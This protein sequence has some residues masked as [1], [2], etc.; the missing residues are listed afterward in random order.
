M[1]KN[2]LII[3]NGVSRLNFHLPTLQKHFVTYGCNALY[4]DHMPDYLISM[5]IHM[6]TEIINARVQYKTKFYTQHINDMDLLA[7]NGEPI[8][9]IKTYASTPD[10]GTAATELAAS[11][12]HTVIYMIGFDHNQGK[13]NNV[14]S[15]TANYHSIG[16]QTPLVQDE[17]WLSRL[18]SIS[19]SY[20]DTRF[21]RVSDEVYDYKL[22]N[23][24]N[25]TIES[26]MEA[27]C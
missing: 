8:N 24:T 15:G 3:G 6:V 4:R 16:Y 2:A 20:P 23:L 26:F 17:K 10:S 11:L 25:L 19:K 14:Y 7:G 21:Y 5:D 1:I 22:N 12:G 13:Y 18:Y 27:I 9:F